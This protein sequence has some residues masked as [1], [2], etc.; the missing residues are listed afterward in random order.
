M[1]GISGAFH[2]RTGAPVEPGLL[3]AIGEAQRHRGPDEGDV[4]CDGFVGLGHRR[5]SVIDAVG[6][7]Q[8]M[9]NEDGSIRV[10][11]NGEIYNFP[12]LR[13]ELMARGQAFRTQ[14][15]TEVLLRLYEHEGPPCVSRLRGMFAFAVW[16]ATAR[17]LLLARDR[18]GKKPLVYAEVA[19]GLVFASEIAA[20]LQDDRIPREL[21]LT[22]LDQYLTHLY[23]PAP[24]TMLRAVR[25]V[26]PGHVLICRE[27]CR[28]LRPY[29]ALSFAEKWSLPE[30]EWIE[31]VRGALTDAVRVRLMSD[32]PLGA[33]LSGGVDSSA[34][35]A[36]MTQLTGRPVRTFSIG[37]AEDAYNELPYARQVA[38]R[39]GSEHHELVVR[40]DA[41][42]VLPELVRH[43]GEPFGD[44][45]ALPFYYLAQMARGQVTVA[46]SGD[47]GDE[48]FA[49]Y[50]RYVK[51]DVRCQM[52][53]VSRK[54]SR[55]SLS[56]VICHL[57]SDICTLAGY[58]LPRGKG[59]RG[60]GER[61]RRLGRF[62]RLSPEARYA[63]GMRYFPGSLKERLLTPEARGAIAAEG[64]V[65]LFDDLF[66]GSDGPELL[67]R[68]L[69]VDTR[70]YLPDDLLVKAD[71]AA[72]AH[73]LEVRSPFL[74]APL[75]ELAARMPASLKLRDGETKFV[76]KRALADLL[77]PEIL[78]RPKAGF[79][80]PLNRWLRGPLRAYTEE[81]LLHGPASRRG[82]FEMR[83]LREYVAEH[84]D[85]RADHSG[86]IWGLMNLE[87][88][89]QMVLDGARC[90]VL[91]ARFGTEVR[92]SSSVCSPPSTEHRAPSTGAQR[93]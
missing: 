84:M 58:C 60:P 72:M 26:P 91:G 15:D 48:A 87:L 49:G 28:E 22:A 2:D 8:P 37:F 25:K 1:C 86:Q 66:R 12:E 40:P 45:S 79:A 74:D 93:P 20:L 10:V 38:Q 41:V 83:W 16:D 14:S 59:S 43:Y 65:D 69:Q 92:K 35:V 68:L 7:K 76:L 47:G 75:M 70:S 46:L 36:L 29:A 6:G 31:R 73:S 19:D 30:A 57:S 77:P 32:V 62:L 50:E 3:R 27:G 80:L 5:L 61:L 23:V 85:G 51:A 82:L 39:L 89:Q 81:L 54:G 24:R 21:D 90:S 88:W 18:V 44:S 71:I 64:A 53:D 17:Q 42:A 52:S 55:F 78:S 56:S 34:V 67:D 13:E 9:S 11:L 33:L 63:E 4:W